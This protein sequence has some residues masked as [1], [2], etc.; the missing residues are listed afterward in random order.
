[1]H[2]SKGTLLLLLAL[3]SLAVSLKYCEV[4]DSN[5][6][7]FA[8]SQEVQQILLSKHF[9]GYDLDYQSSNPSIMDVYEPYHVTQELP[10]SLQAGYLPINIDSKNSKDNLWGRDGVVVT[11]S[12]GKSIGIGYGT[13]KNDVLP[14]INFTYF[15]LPSDAKCYSGR[16]Y[17]NDMSVV[18]DCESEDEDL[19]CLLSSDGSQQCE[20]YDSITQTGNRISLIHTTPSNNKYLLSAA[21]SRHINAKFVNETFINIYHIRENSRADF[22]LIVD[23]RAL[24]L[25]SL[26]ITDMD[27]IELS[28]ITYVLVADAG[29]WLVMFRY[30][31]DNTIA[32]VK[33]FEVE[34]SPM[35]V[36]VTP[37][38]EIIVATDKG[39]L[40]YVY[41]A[42][43]TIALGRKYEVDPSD[44][45]VTDIQ[46]SFNHITV[47]TSLNNIYTYDRMEPSLKFLLNRESVSV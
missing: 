1:M 41:T 19:L 30:M 24:G 39:L 21:S 8:T 29:G 17:N 35:Q 6:N 44:N 20:T 37:Y 28:G 22:N 42:Q 13:F 43:G 11:Q 15:T 25:D 7:L 4:E 18:L 45:D 3:L 38:S 36:E 32:D 27:L 16:I 12:N 34:G 46:S 9:R 14:T 33:T 2:N 23:R 47:R 5:V 10:L 26:S 40:V 31:P